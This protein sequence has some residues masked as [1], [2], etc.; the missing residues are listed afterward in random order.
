MPERIAS[1][2]IFKI[3]KPD[4]SFW[5]KWLGSQSTAAGLIFFL[6]RSGYH[7]G[8]HFW[9]WLYYVSDAGLADFSVNVVDTKKDAS[10]GMTSLKE[11][12]T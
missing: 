4:L 11:M 6:A 9:E 8:R 10:D 1:N 12:R 5:K 2:I 7:V 3:T